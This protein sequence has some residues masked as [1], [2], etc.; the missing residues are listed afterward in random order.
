MSEMMKSTS[1]KVIR[2]GWESS[3][4]GRMPW[5]C[6]VVIFAEMLVLE[7]DFAVDWLGADGF[8]ELLRLEGMEMVFSGSGFEGGVVV[9]ELWLMRMAAGSLMVLLWLRGSSGAV[10]GRTEEGG[11]VSTLKRI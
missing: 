9:D 4:D 5:L 7:K 6:A 1:W 11:H 8:V 2:E 10:D 3:R